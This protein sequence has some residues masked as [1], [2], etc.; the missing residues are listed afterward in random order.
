MCDWVQSGSQKELAKYY[1]DFVSKRDTE[2]PES[3]IS[4]V[5]GCSFC[6][7]QIVRLK[8]ALSGVRPR[9]TEGQ[10]PTHYGVLDMLDSHFQS[11][12]EPVTCSRVRCF[13]PGLVR[14]FPSLRV[15]TPITVHV[16]HCPAC[17]QDLEILRDLALDGGQLERLRWVY[18]EKA[19]IG[20][21]CGVDRIC[22]RARA[23]I[24]AFIRG[25]FKGLDGGILSHLSACPGCRAALYAYRQD[26]LNGRLNEGTPSP[27]TSC[28][29]LCAADLFD[30]V[31][32]SPEMM[33][34]L[35]RI[36][37]QLDGW[38]GALHVGA[39]RT[40]L[41]KVQALHRTIYGI[42][43]RPDSDVATVYTTLRETETV[44]ATPDNAYADYLIRVQVVQPQPQSTVAAPAEAKPQAQRI[45][46]S[47]RVRFLLKTAVAAAAVIPLSLLFFSTETASGITLAQIVN[48]FGEAKNVHVVK[49]HPDTGKV[50]GEL[51]I[52]RELSLVIVAEGGT[53]VVRN[54][55]TRQK[56]YIDPLSMRRE[57]TS[58]G[59]Q[60][61]A[62]A[63]RLMDSCLGFSMA[64][65]PSNAEWN[66]VG[67]EDDHTTDVYELTWM[68]RTY[69]NATFFRKY[70]VVVDRST[71]LPKMTKVFLRRNGIQTEWE[72]RAATVF[73]YM[74][75]DEMRSVIGANSSWGASSR[76]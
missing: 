43:E 63:R 65:V 12:D 69:S 17:A 56:E 30:W 48:A 24:P 5:Q 35:E 32:P 25:S 71:K 37:D 11:L 58:L 52:S 3:V 53:L 28:D 68:D 22:R 45:P 15:P 41:E 6:R 66:R 13:L 75:T 74:T 57:V 18:Q 59:R 29:G 2:I 76:L 1:Y 50:V 67:A 46:F 36:T 33:D 23:A 20:R 55:A 54:L 8:N 72:C 34:G 73:T 10:V 61:Y 27:R 26:L 47:P 21:L 31:V 9:A 14:P 62:N 7:G 39:C 4:H 60:E 70:E 42:V 19:G 38:A 40:C 51:W 64:G 44:V 16:D 49:I